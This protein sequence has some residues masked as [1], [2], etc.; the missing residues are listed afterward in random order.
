MTEYFETSEQCKERTFKDME[1]I[2]SGKNAKNHVALHILPWN[3]EECLE[4]VRA[5]PEGNKINFSELARH[6]GVKNNN[7]EFPKNGGQFVKMFLQEN[8]IN[9]DSL[10]YKNKSAAVHSR[11][12]KRKIDG[13]NV[14]IPTDVTN[15]EVKEYLAKLINYTIGDLIVPQTIVLN[16]DLT[17]EIKEFEIAGRKVPLSEIRKK[18]YKNYKQFYRIFTESQIKEMDREELVKELKRIDEFSKSDIYMDINTLQQRFRKF[19][20]TRNLQ[21]WHDG[22][23]ISNHSHLLM[24][25]NTLYDKTIHMTDQEYEEKHK[26]KVDVQS[27]IEKPYIYILARC[28]GDDHQ[29]MYS[30]CRNEDIRSK[31]PN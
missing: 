16:A 9:F 20:T 26:R 31:I 15:T 11:R 13:I 5:Y 29:L 2:E 19:N 28:P 8:G 22:S 30:D 18:Q 7:N 4:M 24:T 10:N 12:K 1:K 27:E 25:V 6:Y 14:S 21:F 17:T 23:S 3:E